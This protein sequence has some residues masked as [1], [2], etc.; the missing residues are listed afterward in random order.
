MFIFV[1]KSSSL[2]LLLK[3]VLIVNF[4]LKE[5]IMPSKTAAKSKVLVRFIAILCYVTYFL[6]VNGSLSLHYNLPDNLPD[7][8]SPGETGSA[9]RVTQT[10][11]V[12]K[13]THL[14]NVF[15][16]AA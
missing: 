13:V 7:K 2:L 16:I 8:A 10:E 15:P 3:V 4:D 11:I 14:Y 5:L 1:T 6:S 9:S 12:Y